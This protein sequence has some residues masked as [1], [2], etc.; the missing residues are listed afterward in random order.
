[1]ASADP[2]LEALQEEWAP[3]WMIWRA[4]RSDDPPG[5]RTGEFVA[6][7]LQDEAGAER[8]VMRATAAEL[9]AV[10]RQQKELAEQG[11]QW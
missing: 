6:T 2:E 11:V 5:A 4:R 1:M 3:A 7:R 8:T 9:D 10:L